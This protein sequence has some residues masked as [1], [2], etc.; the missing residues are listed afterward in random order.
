[1][2]ELRKARE[3]G[4]VLEGLAVALSNV[5]EFIALIKAAPTPAVAQERTDGARLALAL[6]ARCWLARRTSTMSVYRP[7]ALVPRF[8]PAGRW[9]YRLSDVQAQRI[10][11]MRLQRLTGLEQDKIVNEY[12][13]MMEQ[14]ADLLDILAKPARVTEIIARR[15]HWRLETE[16][17]D[18][19]RSEID[20]RTRRTSSTE[21]LITPEDVVVTLSHGGYMKSA[22]AGG[23][24]RAEARRPRQAGDGD[25]RKT[26]SSISS[27]SPTRTTTILCF[28]NRG[29]LYWLKVYEVPQGARSARGKPIV[30]MFPLIG[31]REDH[32]RAAGQA[33]STTS[34]SSSWRPRWA[35]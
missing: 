17:G 6:V 11:E 21:D 19:R 5:D 14:I 26:I 33:S 18:E 27:S 10:L 20:R 24:P 28:S 7:E 30:N 4:H 34:T 1:M 22:A 2:F 31:E 9:A 13:D 29:R 23:L 32:G 25:A 12:R 15:A 8:R 35:R 16:F 3:R